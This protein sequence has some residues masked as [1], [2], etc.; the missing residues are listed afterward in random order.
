MPWH[1]IKT[2]IKPNLATFLKIKKKII[3]FSNGLCGKMFVT[4]T[5]EMQK[6]KIKI[7]SNKSYFRQI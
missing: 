6:K 1:K 5:Y 3:N 4:K 2:T 7:N